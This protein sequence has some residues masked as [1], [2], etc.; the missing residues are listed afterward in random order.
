MFNTPFPNAFGLDIS[1]LSIKLVQLENTSNRFLGSYSYKIKNAREIT[2]PAGLI[3]NGEIIQPEKVVS[4]IIKIL[5]GTKKGEK[6]INSS[7]VVAS[8]PELQSFIKLIVL[9]KDKEEIIDEDILIEAKKHIP[10]TED[11]KYYLDW[12]I[13]PSIKE[14][15]TRILISAIM[16][17]T[18][19]SYTKLLESVGLGIVALENE[20]LSI[21]R[22]TVTAS[23]EYKNEARGLLDIGA[24]RSSFIVYDNETVQ[25][26]ADFDF[27]GELL[28]VALSQKMKISREEAEEIKIKY[29]LQYKQQKQI[30]SLLMDYSKNFAA[31]LR[32]AIYF[33]YSHFPETNRIKH[34]TMCG[35]GSTLKHLD[36]VLSLELKNECRLGHVWKNLNNKKT[37]ELDEKKY[38]GYATAIGL[39]LRA[40]DNPFFIKDTI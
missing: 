34:I 17:E 26:T 11:E 27:S 36:K 33:Y 10:F 15:T 20:A 8:L 18:A 35:S 13:L 22:S 31:E 29:G 14:K 16:K 39:A 40:A 3:V 12:D 4:Y 32:K 28:T 25:F 6:K 24:T 21:A 23:K 1:D 19:D 37:L 38:L 9:N 2:L 7:W 5:Q 30:W